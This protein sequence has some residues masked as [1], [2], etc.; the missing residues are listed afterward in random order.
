M[1]LSTHSRHQR[2]T[3]RTTALQGNLKLNLSLLPD[4]PGTQLLSE[5]HLAEWP[6][7][8]CVI[9]CDHLPGGPKPCGLAHSDQCSLAFRE[10]FLE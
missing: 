2:A 1:T 8:V 7:G 5:Q 3:A 9:I 4:S 6:Q 10:L